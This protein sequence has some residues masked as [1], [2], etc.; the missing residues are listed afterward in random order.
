MMLYTLD[1]YC[2]NANNESLAGI[3]NQFSCKNLKAS[4]IHMYLQWKVLMICHCDS[5]FRLLD[6]YIIDNNL[7]MHQVIVKPLECLLKSTQ[8]P[9]K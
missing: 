3:R 2:K 6:T 9:G 8:T 1:N 4:Y 7:P 5:I